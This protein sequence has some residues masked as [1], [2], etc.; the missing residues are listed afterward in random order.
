[1]K[2]NIFVEIIF[3]SFIAD[4]SFQFIPAGVKMSNSYSVLMQCKLI[5]IE[6]RELIK[7]TFC[8]TDK[9][10]TAVFKG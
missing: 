5:S 3:Y 8:R 2:G 10:S 6:K 1:M 4:N 9:Q 7:P